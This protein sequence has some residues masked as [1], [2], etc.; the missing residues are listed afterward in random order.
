MIGSAIPCSSYTIHKDPQMVSFWDK[1]QWLCISLCI[2]GLAITFFG[3]I[4]FFAQSRLLPNSLS[5]LRTIDFLGFK[6]SMG[7]IIGGGLLS[8]AALLSSSLRLE[9]KQKVQE[10][11]I[12]PPTQKR[13]SLEHKPTLTLPATPKRP[14][15]TIYPTVTGKISLAAK[16]ELKEDSISPFLDDPDSEVKETLIA[17]TFSNLSESTA[18]SP[19]QSVFIPARFLQHNGMYKKHGERVQFVYD[20]KNYKLTLEHPLAHQVSEKFKKE[21]Y[22]CDA[23]AGT[24]TSIPQFRLPLYPIVHRFS[25]YFKLDFSHP[26]SPEN[27]WFFFFDNACAVYA[28]SESTASQPPHEYLYLYE[29]PADMAAPYSWDKAFSEFSPETS[30]LIFY[31]QGKKES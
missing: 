12:T 2:A 8:F 24:N 20:H 5:F 14:T 1:K 28:F 13:E 26:I 9:K 11:P 21:Q 3:V 6:F 30:T 23:Q 17:C 16:F 31:P 7:L 19:E 25:N 4:G 10:K 18:I 29:P 22:R 15:R 27:L